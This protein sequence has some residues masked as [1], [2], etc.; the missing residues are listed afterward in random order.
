ME[1]VR[2]CVVWP[3]EN[4]LGHLQGRMTVWGCCYRAFEIG[5]LFLVCLLHLSASGRYDN[6]RSNSA[7]VVVLLNTRTVVMVVTALVHLI[8]D[9]LAVA[10]WPRVSVRWRPPA[11]ATA[12]AASS[13]AIGFG[14][15][16]DTPNNLS[17]LVTGTDVSVCTSMVVGGWLQVKALVA[18]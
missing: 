13:G 2:L 6:C 15:E 16:K 7:L 18:R 3:M 5:C 17:F 12:S 14:F 4:W 10:R 9:M 1:Q 11:G 8:L